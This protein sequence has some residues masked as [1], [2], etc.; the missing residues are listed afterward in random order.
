MRGNVSVQRVRAASEARRQKALLFDPQANE[1]YQTQ[2]LKGEVIGLGGI[3]LTTPIALEKR[4]LELPLIKAYPM[5]E[6]KSCSST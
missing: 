6:S 4:F 5:I 2:A 3:G 1:P